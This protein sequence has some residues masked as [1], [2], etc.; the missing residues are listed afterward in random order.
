MLDTGRMKYTQHSVA[1]PNVPL[2]ERV[3]DEISIEFESGEFYVRW[4]KL[5]RGESYVPRIECFFDS[6]AGLLDHKILTGVLTSLPGPS[7]RSG[8]RY[9]V[10]Y[11]E[12]YVTPEA[13]VGLLDRAE[14]EPSVYHLR[15]LIEHTDLSLAEKAEMQGRLARAEKADADEE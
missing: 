4:W 14:I 2:P 7:I 8:L 6:L 13:F 9:T 1:F 10:D 15:G 5:G 11:K 3:A 12:K